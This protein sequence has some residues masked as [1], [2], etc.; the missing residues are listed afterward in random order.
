MSVEKG[1]KPPGIL[2]DSGNS[3]KSELRDLIKTRGK[4]RGRIT[5]F[6]KYINSLE[7]TSLVDQQ[8][9]ELQLRVASAEEVFCEF[10]DIQNKIENII[11]DSELM[12][13]LE[14]RETIESQYYKVM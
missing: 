5:F 6:G 12:Q 11:S 7:K 3:D 8:I 1:S 9:V 2:L 4:L 14:I 13:Q 10:Q